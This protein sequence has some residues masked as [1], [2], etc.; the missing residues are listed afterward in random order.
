MQRAGSRS[1]I[2]VNWYYHRCSFFAFTAGLKK[3]ALWLVWKIDKQELKFANGLE[4]FWGGKGIKMKTGV[5]QCLR[6]M[7]EDA[8]FD[9]EAEPKNCIHASEPLYGRR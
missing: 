4:R 8:E 3:M 9:T 1:S 2:T 5:I 7:F 6:T